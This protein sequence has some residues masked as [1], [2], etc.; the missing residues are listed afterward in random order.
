M[1]LYRRGP[2]IGGDSWIGESDTA[3]DSGDPLG[4][5]NR[6]TIAAQRAAEADAAERERE[7][8][9]QAELQARSQQFAGQRD[10]YDA[11]QRAALQQNAL[12]AQAQEQQGQ[13]AQRGYEFNQK[14]KQ[15]YLDW[16]LRGYEG[17]QNRAQ[18]DQHFQQTG[19]QG[20]YEFEQRQGQQA[21]QFGAAHQ[22][23]ADQFA[24]SRQPSPRDQWEADQRQQQQ[25]GAQTFQAQEMQARMQLQSQLQQQELTQAEKMRLQRMQQAVASTQA[26]LDNGKIDPDTANAIMTQLKTGIDPLQKRSQMSQMMHQQMQDQLLMHQAAKAAQI[27]DQNA[28]FSAKTF[29]QRVGQYRDENGMLW[30]GFQKRPGEWD[31]KDPYERMGKEQTRIDSLNSGAETKFL[32]GIESQAN[33]TKSL[34]QADMVRITREVDKSVASAK[35]E[36]EAAIKR[37]PDDP[38]SKALQSWAGKLEAIRDEMIH[39]RMRNN[40]RW[41][42]VGSNGDA[43]DAQLEEWKQQQRENWQPPHKLSQFSQPSPTGQTPNT[44]QRI[45]QQH[46]QDRLAQ[47]MTINPS[48]WQS[49]DVPTPG[50]QAV[51]NQPTNPYGQ[52]QGQAQPPAAQPQAAPEVQGAFQSLRQEADRFF[53][54][55]PSMAKDSYLRDVAKLEQDP[56]NKQLRDYVRAQRDALL[57]S[58]ERDPRRI[59]SGGG[60]APAAPG[61]VMP[62]DNPLLGRVQG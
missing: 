62:N 38:R 36:A 19:Q 45:Q 6:A 25:Q 26:D 15:D 1:P 7:R 22:Q 24:A 53:G 14:A 2:L 31:V 18:Q 4:A 41:A 42:D 29:D 43:L 27:E 55:E 56:A 40:Q 10:V 8:Q 57:R 17:E 44:G 59:R 60:A 5:R 51:M 16:I 21:E 34:H 39:D 11:Q 52:A 58:K 33:K 9:F 12:G 32:Q 54:S 47:P 23:A 28:Q 30:T 49:A 20:A 48:Q 3:D 50:P 13:Q 61:G 46:E 37:D 35:H